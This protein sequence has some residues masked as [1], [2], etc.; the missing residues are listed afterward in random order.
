MEMKFIADLNEL[1]EV[2]A[3]SRIGGIWRERSK[4]YHQFKSHSKAVLNFWTSTSTI[5]F[6]GKY[7]ESYEALVEAVS[8]SSFYLEIS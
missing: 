1:K 6:Q 3:A 4:G 8:S 5:N 2:V 7:G